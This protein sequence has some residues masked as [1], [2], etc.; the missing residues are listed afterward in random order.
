[1]K[2]FSDKVSEKRRSKERELLFYCFYI[3]I[4]LEITVIT[5]FKMIFA[6]KITKKHLISDPNYAL[7]DLKPPM[8]RWKNG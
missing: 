4:I 3:V 6:K 5:S 8:K 7:I 2:Y 1:M